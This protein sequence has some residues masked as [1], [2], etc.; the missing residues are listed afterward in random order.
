MFERMIKPYL[1]RSLFGRAILILLIPIILIQVVVGTVFVDRLFRD[2]TIQMTTAVAKEIRFITRRM[3]EIGPGTASE[4]QL[5]AA[6]AE[7]FGLAEIRKPDIVSCG[8]SDE[9]LFYDVSGRHIINTLRTHIP[10]VAAVDLKGHKKLVQ[11]CLMA[12]GSPVE[13]VFSRL[14][15]SAPNPHQLL[16]AMVIA[17]IL[18]TAIAVVF[19]RKQIN[20]IA[21]LAAASE[22]FGM[23]HS[24]EFRP[25]GALEIRSA[26]RA[27]LSM[28][29]RIE[30]HIK[31]RTLMLS[32]VSHDLRTPITRMKL[33]L[34]LMPESEE[35]RLLKLD[36]AE[37]EK[38]LEEFLTF[39]QGSAGEEV[40][41]ICARNLAEKMVRDRGRSDDPVE[42]LFDR[43]PSCDTEF[44]CRENTLTRAI[45]NLLSNAFRY[46][47]SVRLTV[48]V[49]REWV[50]FIV[51]D[52]GP[53]IPEE[54]RESATEAFSRLDHARNQDQGTSIGLGLAITK[55][56]AQSHGGAL[57]LADSEA[58][59]GLRAEL[60]I[61]R[62][63]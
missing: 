22:S 21:S 54:D 41:R 5:F 50:R 58:L 2:V 24:V 45:D 36:V 51:E 13:I 49:S 63:T 4:E 38:T 55:D 6:L 37:M 53:G 56:V 14:R 42:L 12:G 47:K 28:R 20:P 26:G 19:L 16:V 7:Q 35:I 44:N 23:G 29:D 32:G 18:F 61:P 3:N 31:Q 33:S 52:D 17:S 62:T 59:G 40:R 60:S 11:L 43:D 39:A 1:P 30:R 48:T 34:S 57:V 27:F 25:R 9:K 15:A 46:S 8:S 10:G